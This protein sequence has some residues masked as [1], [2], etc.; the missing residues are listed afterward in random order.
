TFFS[1]GPEGG[2]VEAELIA[3]SDELCLH[4]ADLALQK[5]QMILMGYSSGAT[6]VAAMALRHQDIARALVL[7]RPQQP[8]PQIETPDLSGLPVLIVAGRQDSRRSSE[9]A[10][11]LAGQFATSGAEVAYHVLETGH[12]WEPTGL[13]LTITREWISCLANA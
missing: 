1:K 11:R 5:H 6:I 7:L 4:L 3:R 2:L 13:D 12:D 8:F 10:A 9:D